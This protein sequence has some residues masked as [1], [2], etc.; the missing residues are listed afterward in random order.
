MRDVIIT[1]EN[2]GKKYRIQHQVERRRYK[3]LRDVIA[4]KL[5]LPFSRVF[6]KVISKVV[7]VLRFE[8]FL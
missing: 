8:D 3:A 2:L 6:A 1:V 4:Q 7:A 5:A